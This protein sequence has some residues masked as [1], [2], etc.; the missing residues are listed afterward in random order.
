[1]QNSTMYGVG[2]TPEGINQNYVIYEFALE[3]AWDYQI[4][5]TGKWFSHYA[6]VRYGQH[7]IYIN[8]AWNKLLVRT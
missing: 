2:I 6:K 4:L 1:M 3:K 8:L 5:D 7:D